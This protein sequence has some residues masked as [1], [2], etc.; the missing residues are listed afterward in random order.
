MAILIA[1][2]LWAHLIQPAG[3]AAL[4][5]DATAALYAV[6]RL[7]SRTS[8]MNNLVAEISIRC[9]PKHIRLTLGHLRAVYS[10]EADA[11]SRLSEGA[12]L[13]ASLAG[14]PR[15]RAPVRVAQGFVRGDP[16]AV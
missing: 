16:L 15:A 9:E 12:T 3:V 7:S 5:G 10:I 6:N 11:L 14:V 8:T 1:I 13:P 2:D 4:E